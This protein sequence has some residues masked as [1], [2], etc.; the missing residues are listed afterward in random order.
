MTYRKHKKPMQSAAFTFSG[1]HQMA[2]MMP[3]NIGSRE[4]QP[5]P[6]LRGGEP[7]RFGTGCG[8]DQ[9]RGYG[10]GYR[11]ESPLPGLR[12]A[13]QGGWRYGTS[14]QHVQ[15]RGYGVGYRGPSPLPGMRGAGQGRVFSHGGRPFVCVYRPTNRAVLCMG[16]HEIPVQLVKM[17]RGRRTGEVKALVKVAD[18]QLLKRV[19]IDE[20]H[21]SAARRHEWLWE[22]MDRKSRKKRARWFPAKVMM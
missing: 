15:N 7:R 14:Q 18:G 8:R 16:E 12:G 1:G 20:G 19:M 4:P 9:D 2:S 22:M 17:G 13:G 10:I 3:S 21:G 11:G 5:R 6:G